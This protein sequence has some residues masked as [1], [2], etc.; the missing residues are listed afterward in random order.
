MPNFLTEDLYMYNFSF[1]QNVHS[2]LHLAAKMGH[3][4]LVETLIVSGANIN[5]VAKVSLNFV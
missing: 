1:L 2:P 3:T 4:Q 5:S